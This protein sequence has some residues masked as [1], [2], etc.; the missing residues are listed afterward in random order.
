MLGGQVSSTLG[1]YVHMHSIRS[2]PPYYVYVS[3]WRLNEI[4]PLSKRCFLSTTRTTMTTET[5]KAAAT[6]PTA[7]PT[8]VDIELGA[9]S[10]DSEVELTFKFKRLHLLH[11]FNHTFI[12]IFLKAL[13]FCVNCFSYNTICCKYGLI[14]RQIGE[15]VC[16][17]KRFFCVKI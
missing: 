6:P 4:Q 1:I 2:L 15:H 12:I 3:A 8:T 14:Y 7:P 13:C 11:T 16:S 17:L 10:D 9:V 5:A